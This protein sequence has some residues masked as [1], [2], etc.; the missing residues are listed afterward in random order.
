MDVCEI[1]RQL[2]VKS[3]NI[4]RMD[5]FQSPRFF[6]MNSGETG[7]YRPG[8]DAN[9]QFYLEARITTT[10]WANGAQYDQARRLA[11]HALI[12]RLY[13]DILG[14]MAE[15]RLQISNGN[16]MACLKLLNQME[17]KLT[18]GKD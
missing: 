4:Q 15:L 9:T 11:E 2:H 6:D 3:D 12:H 5:D 14:N 18:N 13:G 1:I 17:A 8:L 7:E 16:R 10:F